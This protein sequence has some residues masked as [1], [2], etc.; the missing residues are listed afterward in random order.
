MKNV[1]VFLASSDELTE[2]RRAVGDLFQFLNNIYVERGVYLRLETWEYESSAIANGRKQDEYNQLIRDSDLCFF[3]FFTKAGQY[4]LEEFGTALSSFRDVG[5]PKIVT[6]V[7]E[8]PEE[9]T[10]DEDLSVFL[11]RLGQDMGHFWNRY[12]QIDTL[13]LTMFQQIV[14]TG[15]DVPYEVDGDHLMVD[16]RELVDLRNVPSY[17]GYQRIQIAQAELD[18][19]QVQYSDLQTKFAIDP[20]DSDLFRKF[21]AV[22]SRHQ[23]LLDELADA[24]KSFMEFTQ[25]LAE[26]SS[27]GERLLPR[28]IQAYRLFECGR[29]DEALQILNRVNLEEDASRA[30]TRHDST[31]QA[32][33]D[34]EQDEMQAYVNAYLDT[35]WMLQS[36]P[37]TPEILTEMEQSLRAAYDIEKRNGLPPKGGFLL[38]SFLESQNRPLEATAICEIF[39]NI[40]LFTSDLAFQSA[41][42]FKLGILYYDLRRYDQAET[43]LTTA[44]TIY[45]KLAQANPNTYAPTL[46][47]TLRKLSDLYS[48]LHCYDQAETTLTTATTIYR[49]LAHTNPNTYAPTLAATLRKLGEIYTHLSRNDQAKTTFTEAFA[50]HRELAQIKRDTHNQDLDTKLADLYWTMSYY[51]QIES[52]VTEAVTVSRELVA[53]NPD[54]YTPILATNLCLLGNLYWKLGMAYSDISYFDKAE[55]LLAEVVTLYRALSDSNPETY[56]LELSGSLDI[57]GCLYLISRRWNEAQPLLAEAV[58]IRRQLANQS[59]SHKSIFEDRFMDFI[60]LF[61]R[62]ITRLGLGHIFSRVTSLLPKQKH[63]IRGTTTPD[64]MQGD[65]YQ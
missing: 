35:Y 18:S 23:E 22:A 63:T 16:G 32:A 42:L 50:L 1:V 26:R 24:R 34:A 54:A 64:A 39:I 7:R 31:I 28:Q 43:T 19:I 29:V 6:F 9:T 46:A 30:Q 8:V 11:N 33:Q 48:D 36:K 3:L 25:S 20:T 12:G 58:R 62:C 2:D 4:T 61:V 27:S 44:T 41:V 38:V 53:T 13:K 51:G 14:L 59:A 49:K 60:S 5:K 37:V 21:G 47:A 52:V 56:C 15:A 55:S 17:Q 45:R 40:P 10:I 57:L 65:H